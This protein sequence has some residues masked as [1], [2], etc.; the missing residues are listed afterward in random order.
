[1]A[2]ETGSRTPRFRTVVLDMDSTLSGVEGIDWLAARRQPDVSA[3]SVSLT[4]AAMAGDLPLEDVYARRLGLVAPTEQDVAAL[5]DA[6]RAAVAP[7]ARECIAALAQ[8][9]V[10]VL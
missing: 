5:S 10:R 7:G 1:M 4:D 2:S 6:Y 8:A 9:N 3:R